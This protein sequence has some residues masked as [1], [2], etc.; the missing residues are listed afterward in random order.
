MHEYAYKYI[1]TSKLC[2]ANEDEK[3][4]RN[5]TE[6][7]LFKC[8]GESLQALILVACAVLWVGVGSLFPCWEVGMT[9]TL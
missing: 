6:K 1:C 4:S 7:T 5:V 3:I 9:P 8:A 2:C